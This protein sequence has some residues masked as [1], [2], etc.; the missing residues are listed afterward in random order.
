MKHEMHSKCEY[1]GHCLVQIV[2]T[3]AHCGSWLLTAQNS[4][5]FA[6][7]LPL[8]TRF[9]PRHDPG[10]SDLGPG[11]AT[12]PGRG[13]AR[14]DLGARWLFIYLAGGVERMSYATTD[15]GVRL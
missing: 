12:G 5:G 7:P 6:R 10:P 9:M 2:D 11:R 3:N 13:G 15:D 1:F 8:L 4:Y 14:S